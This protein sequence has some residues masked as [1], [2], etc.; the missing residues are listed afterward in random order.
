MD[1][2]AFREAFP[3]FA[4]TTAYPEAR[5]VAASEFA[6]GMLSMERWGAQW[7]YATMLYLAHLLVITGPSG[8]GGGGGTNGGGVSGLATSK[9]VDKVSVSYDVAAVTYTGA[10]FW[11]LSRYGVELWM[12]IQMFGAGPIQVMG[13]TAIVPLYGTG[14]GTLPGFLFP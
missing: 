1:I 2:A 14:Y 10:G 6:E 7:S 9:S 4:D 13:N 5:L 3:Q 12:L 8:A 11:N